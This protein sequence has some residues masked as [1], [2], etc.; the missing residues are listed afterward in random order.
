MNEA[1]DIIGRFHPVLL[2]LPIG[3]L[4]YGFL[5]F[6]YDVWIKKK[7][8]PVDLTFVLGIGA[9]SSV[10]TAASGL[11]LSNNG[12]YSGLTLEWHKWL[13]VASSGIAIALYVIYRRRG[14]DRT[15]HA[16]FLFLIGLLIV[17]GHYGGSITH[18]EGFLFPD[19][20][21]E[22]SNQLIDPTKANIFND[23]VM[24]IAKDKCNRCHNAKKKKGDLLLTTLEGWKRGGKNGLLLKVGDQENSLMYHRL[25]LPMDEKKHMPP[26]GKKQLTNEELHFLDWWIASVK[27]FEETVDDLSPPKP[28]L[29]YIQNQLK[30]IEKSLAKISD[31][32]IQNFVEDGIPIQRL[33]EGSPWLSLEYENGLNIKSSHLKKVMKYKDNIRK[34]DASKS[35]IRDNDLK[36]INEF[37]NLVSLNLGSNTITSKGLAY[38]TQLHKLETLNLYGTSVD[39]EVLNLLSNFPGL[40]S[41]YLSES[42][43]EMNQNDLQAKFGHI[44]LFTGPDLTIFEDAKVLPPSFETT[45]DIFQDSILVALNHFSS[46]AKIYYTTDQQDPTEAS[47]LYKEPIQLTSSNQVR[48]I[49][50]LEG[51]KNSEVHSK[52]FLKSGYAPVLCQTDPLPNEKYTGS[53][54]RTLIDQEKGSEQFGDGKWLGFQGRDVSVTLDLGSENEVKTISMGCLNDYKSYIFTPVGITVSGSSD[55]NHYERFVHK[56]YNQITGPVDVGV[57]DFILNVAEIKVRYI[58][59]DF[60]AQKRNPSWHSDPGAECWLFLDEIIID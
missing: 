46:N 17:T 51:W 12:D 35:G 34:I 22:F 28:I 21:E 50:T 58:K 1:I 3:I 36:R 25:H 39:N 4:I 56:K 20:N 19:S 16:F 40:K 5:H 44:N 27:T 53:G 47:T 54:E 38:L 45:E 13:G 14:G 57:R 33:S 37:V 32:E 60:T 55:G 59:I 10:L 18:G 52:A 24:P 26:S 15:F 8:N 42:K 7:E 31:E 11:L 23:L 9:I 30:V 41:I 49:A 2:H 29:D 43:V 6:S 48:A